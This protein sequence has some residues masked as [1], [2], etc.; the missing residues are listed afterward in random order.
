M[1]KNYLQKIDQSFDLEPS[2][3]VM[4][5]LFRQ[6]ERVLVESL[7][8]SFAL[9]FLVKDQYGGDVDTIHNVRKI[10]QDDKMT[11]KNVLNQQEYE[12]REAYDPSIY[13]KDDRYI[14]KGR[15]T[16]AQKEAG[17][18][19]D[20]YT[21]ERVARNAKVDIDHVISAKE[22]ADDRGR[23][24]SGLDGV[25]LANSEDNLQPT[26]RSINRSMKE[27]SV[28]EY[29]QWLQKTDPARAAELEKLRGKPQSELTDKERAKLHKY[30]QQA[31]VDQERIKRCDS[32][33]RRSYEAK[34]KQAYYTSPQF[35][36]DVASAAGNVG[37]RMGARQ[38]AG[39][40]F[41]EMW[42]AVKEEF[43]N[44]DQEADFDM[45]D[46]LNRIGRGLKRGCEN[47]KRKYADLFSRCLNGVAAGALSSITTTLCNIFFTTAKNVVRMI[48]QAYPSLVEATKVLFINP[49]CYTFGERMRAVAKVLATG[50]S[51][52]TGVAVSDAVS[53]TPIAAIPVLGDVVPAFCGAFVSGIMSCTFLYFLDRSP[54]INKLVKKLDDLHTIE[55][56][57][58][59]YREQAEYFERYAAELMEIDLAEFQRETALYCNATARLEDAQNENDLN[60]ILKNAYETLNISL[61]WGEHE[62]FDSF[63]EDE[64]AHLVFE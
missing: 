11:Y 3:P 30:E 18:L 60:A 50:A 36:K 61:P 51:V 16:K 32:T 64:S 48:R 28:N 31:A 37:I 54:I 47:A 7:V 44:S 40:M 10:G 39:F 25:D 14:A 27:M 5:G 49:E 8:T 57:V 45:K 53:K 24:L 55:T 58:N 1:Q 22:I 19:V 6:Y 38:A 20:A 13:H 62:S 33:A 46:F 26:D 9:D 42:F 35:A 12:Q 23:V 41:A 43:Q 21:G 15:E 2:E 63:M 4:N 56:E 34:L 17:T 52:V 29:C 59:Y